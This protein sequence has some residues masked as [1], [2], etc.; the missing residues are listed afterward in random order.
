LN[1]TQTARMPVRLRRVGI[2]LALLTSLALVL[3]V[4][5]HAQDETGADLAFPTTLDEQPLEVHTFTGPEYV[6]QFSGGEASDTTF[7]EGTEALVEGVGKTLDDLTVKSTLFEPSPGNHVVVVAFNIDGSEAREFA[8]D[9][10]QL[11]LGDVVEPDLLLRPVAGK[12]VLRVVDAAMPGVYPR[13]VFVNEDTVWV[14]EGDEEYVWDALDQLPD[15][16][17]AGAEE[18]IQMIAQLPLELDGRRRTG[19]YEATEPLFL[20]SLSERL[21]PDLE[22]WLLDLHLDAGLTPAEMIGAITWWGIEDSQQSVQIEGFQL[23]DGDGQMM[24]SL[25]SDVILAEGVD[26]PG[27][28]RSEGQV[29]G[30]DVV[31]LDFETIKQHIFTSNDTVWV[32]TDHAGE[33]DMAAEA[34]A[35][36]P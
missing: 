26:A 1:T 10:I 13:T 4:A 29:G 19:L 15:R 7:I 31:T 36:L 32:V 17:P 8:P 9:A 2:G 25:L 12:W 18:G 20:P 35:A 5:A 21:G 3:P 6:A 22:Q 24:Q 30:R 28:S 16:T 33:P 27:V 34:V 23:P 11:L 14:I